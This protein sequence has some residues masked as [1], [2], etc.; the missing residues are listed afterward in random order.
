MSLVPD[1][2]SDSTNVEVTKVRMPLRITN[3][4][5]SASETTSS[6]STTS[7][8][9]ESK[10]QGNANNESDSSSKIN[11]N[12]VNLILDEELLNNDKKN[13]IPSDM[14][15]IKYNWA[16]PS[17]ATRRNNIQ[18]RLLRIIYNAFIDTQS[19]YSSVTDIVITSG[20][21]PP[22]W[23]WATAIVEG[24][25]PK[26][27]SNQRRKSIRHD[28]GFA[29]DVMIKRKIITDRGSKKVYTCLW[30]P[31]DDNDFKIF[32]LFIENCIKYGAGSIGAGRGYMD[33]PESAEKK[34]SAKITEKRNGIHVDIAFQ[35]NTY[36][37]YKEKNEII[38]NALRKSGKYKS[39]VVDRFS[40]D[41]S[42]KTV[43]SKNDYWGEDLSS[44]T[45]ETWLRT[46]FNKPPAEGK[47]NV[48]TVSNGSYYD[49][50]NS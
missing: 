23:K 10:S 33:Y 20:G 35:N 43:S 3:K 24:T 4:T 19:I 28:L 22:L 32:K 38:K 11:P 36:E 25:N 15:N 45:A 21:E 9:R 8:V 17:Y 40:I 7:S 50:S 49:G 26:K 30:N 31:H 42:I 2:S 37:N 48:A 5:Y 12:D 18:P 41:D 16:N 13:N 39:E 6:A 34:K 14:K 46:I 44:N 47:F 29:A 27:Y 1:S